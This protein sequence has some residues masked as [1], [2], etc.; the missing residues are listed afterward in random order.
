MINDVKE[1]IKVT[2]AK[3]V[4][5]FINKMKIRIVRIAKASFEWP[6]CRLNPYL[7]KIYSK[8]RT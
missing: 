2:K 3:L 1:I 8:N 7:N 5:F 6:S 4:T